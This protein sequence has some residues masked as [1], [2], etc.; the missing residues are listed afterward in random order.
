MPGSGFKQA[1]GTFHIRTTILVCLE[2]TKTI[3]FLIFDLNRYK[4]NPNNTDAYLFYFHI[5]PFLQPAEDQFQD[6]V[7]RFSSFHRG[8]MR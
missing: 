6:I 8:F 7:D 5:F 4:K 2:N 1:E 3:L